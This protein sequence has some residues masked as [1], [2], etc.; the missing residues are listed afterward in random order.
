MKSGKTKV[1]IG[2]PNEY[3]FKLATQTSARSRTVKRS[4]PRDPPPV[5]SIK[6]SDVFDTNNTVD[7]Y[8]SPASANM[9]GQTAPSTAPW[10][11]NG[12]NGFHPHPVWFPY[13]TRGL[14][15]V[16]STCTSPVGFHQSNSP[17]RA[18]PNDHLPSMWCQNDLVRASEVQQNVQSTEPVRPSNADEDLLCLLV[19]SGLFDQESSRDDG[20]CSTFSLDDISEEYMHPLPF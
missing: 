20:L 9:A 13:Y 5:V 19:A 6:Q 2:A 18:R 10:M 17:V 16:I 15:P 11:G 7:P 4:E 1:G 3:N 14:P 8:S 12:S